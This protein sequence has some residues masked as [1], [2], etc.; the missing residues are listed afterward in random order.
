MRDEVSPPTRA[1]LDELRRRVARV[2]DRIR[3]E[4]RQQDRMLRKIHEQ[5]KE[6][7]SLE[8]ERHGVADPEDEETFD[9]FLAD[10][11]ELTWQLDLLGELDDE[12]LLAALTTAAQEQELFFRG[13]SSWD[14]ARV[15]IDGSLRVANTERSHPSHSDHV[16]VGRA[17]S[18]LASV[19]RVR[20]VTH[21]GETPQVWL[22]GDWK[23]VRR[24][25]PGS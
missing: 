2:E 23:G 13:V 5:M 8:R 15:L 17:L 25:R 18:R 10:H 12:K 21:P 4:A 1:E 24:G 9:E 6:L 16:R 7:L 19:G 20:R 3:K 22:P 14:V 11:P